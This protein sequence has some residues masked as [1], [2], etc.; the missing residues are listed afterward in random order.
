M[1]R[2]YGDTGK[3]QRC[4]TVI[5]KTGD[6]K[7]FRERMYTVVRKYVDTL[8]FASFQFCASR[9]KMRNIIYYIRSFIMI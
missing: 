4:G 2:D 1:F 3:S 8:E 9:I 7:V 5:G 6:C